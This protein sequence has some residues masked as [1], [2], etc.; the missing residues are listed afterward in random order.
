[1]MPPISRVESPSSQSAREP[2]LYKFLTLRNRCQLK[3][4]AGRDLSVAPLVQN[5]QPTLAILFPCVLTREIG[6]DQ[7]LLSFTSLKK[8]FGPLV[9]RRPGGLH[10]NP[11]IGTTDE[12]TSINARLFVSLLDD[13]LAR[14]E[15]VMF[16]DLNIANS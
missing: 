2:T 11:M 4:D 8:G 9:Q 5:S 15:A 16:G 7:D 13:W 14:S 3:F 6:V 12:K 10:E 1:M